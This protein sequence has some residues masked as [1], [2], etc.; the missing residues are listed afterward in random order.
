MIITYYFRKKLLLNDFQ[1]E[2]HQVG[3]K[4]NFVSDFEKMYRRKMIDIIKGGL[5][6]L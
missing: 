1:P 3:D 5:R 4:Y 2:H 6:D